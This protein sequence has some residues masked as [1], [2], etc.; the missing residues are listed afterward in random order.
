MVFG[1]GRS[2]SRDQSFHSTFINRER[3]CFVRLRF[4]NALVDV[5]FNPLVDSF[6]PRNFWQENQRFIETL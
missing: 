1:E 4:A 2:L 6:Y 3:V 5:L